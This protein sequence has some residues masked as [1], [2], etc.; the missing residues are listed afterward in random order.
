MS[1]ASLAFPLVFYSPPL[2]KVVA[3]GAEWT[4]ETLVVGR[5]GKARRLPGAARFSEAEGRKAC[6]AHVIAQMRVD[7]DTANRRGRGSIGLVAIVDL[8]SWDD[9]CLAYGV[10]ES[11]AKGG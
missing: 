2:R 3:Q 4:F 6:A 1:G 8:A 10:P 5:D 9:L 7:R 11:G